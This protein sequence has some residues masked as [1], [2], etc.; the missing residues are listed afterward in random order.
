MCVIGR[1]TNVKTQRELACWSRH[2]RH[3]QTTPC[4]GAALLACRL[5]K[6]CGTEVMCSI[7]KVE[8]PGELLGQLLLVLHDQ[9]ALQ[10]QQQ[11][12][13]KELGGG[14]LDCHQQQHRQQGTGQCSNPAE[15]HSGRHQPWQTGTA[16][17][18][19]AT[20]QEAAFVVQL[21]HSLTGRELLC[22][23]VVNNCL[24]LRHL[25]DMHLHACVVPCLRC[26]CYMH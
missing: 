1:H 18:V 10:A 15:E 5:L 3:S 7:F 4:Y 19:A 22:L 26:F 24:L 11:H 6:L 12:Q 2:A 17:L 14:T 21:L 8:I 25:G 9:W 20:Q 23:F 13:S 16:S